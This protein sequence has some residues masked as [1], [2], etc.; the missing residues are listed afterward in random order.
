[1]VISITGSARKRESQETY[2]SKIFKN[3]VKTISS[4]KFVAGLTDGLFA[5]E[6]LGDL[7]PHAVFLG[8]L[9]FETSSLIPGV[10][11]GDFTGFHLIVM[12]ATADAV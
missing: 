9:G 10:D 4:F 2:I 5:D 1:M 11:N 7:R 6:F 8:S 3:V 12:R